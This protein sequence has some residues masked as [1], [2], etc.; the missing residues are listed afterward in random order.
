[1]NKLTVTKINAIGFIFLLILLHLIN[2]SMSPIWQPISEY[3]L[4]NTGW[5]MQIVFFLLGISFLTLGL[6]LIKYLPKIGSKIGGVLLVI[7]SLG[8]FLA[9]IFNTDPV[10]TLPEYMTMSGQI[11][12]AAAGL[13]GFMILATVFIT[14]QFRKQEQL[15]PFRKN[16]FVFTIILWGLEVALI[17]AMGVYLSETNGMITPE[18]PIGWL[19]RIVI[20]FCAIWVWSCAHYLQKSNFKN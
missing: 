15:K 5:L 6:Y 7:A 14:Y 9:G 18:T 11:H 1:M 19:G 13:L 2:T 8:N 17:I 4:G 20:V 16:M 10:D 3:A 12:N